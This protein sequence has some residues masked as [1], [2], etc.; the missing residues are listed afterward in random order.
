MFPVC[1]AIPGQPY[2]PTSP[3]FQGML[4]GTLTADLAL[5]GG[6]LAQHLLRIRQ[7]AGVRRTRRGAPRAAI[8][9]G[10]TMPEMALRFIL[11]NPDVSTVIPG[12]RVLRHV[13]ANRG[14][15]RWRRARS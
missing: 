10:M 5:A 4:T 14:G 8:P 3:S 7:P 2:R 9:P 6:R 11:S 15:E 13:E 1:R 12:M